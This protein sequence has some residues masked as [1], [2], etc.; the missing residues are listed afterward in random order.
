[1]EPYGRAC[2]RG[3]LC[4][5]VTR[6]RDVQM[7]DS[8]LFLGVS[9]NVFPKRVAFEWVNW[10]K[11]AALLKVN[12]QH[13]TCWGPE[14]NKG[15]GSLRGSPP[16]PCPDPSPPAWWGHQPSPAA[17]LELKPPVFPMFGVWYL[18][19]NLHH[20]FPRTPDNREKNME[21]LSPHNWHKPIF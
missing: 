12:R 11:Q 7:S 9:V 13:S 21:C 14:K 16:W 1:M 18:D 5:N 19:W 3:L 2:P 10:G 6:L 8:T 4:V 15:G 17:G 20:G